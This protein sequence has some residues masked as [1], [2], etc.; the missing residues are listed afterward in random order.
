MHEWSSEVLLGKFKGIR[1]YGSEPNPKMQIWD[2]ARWVPSRKLPV[3]TGY[4]FTYAT[5]IRHRVRITED[6]R[7]ITKIDS[8]QYC[9]IECFILKCPFFLNIIYFR[10]FLVSTVVSVIQSKGFI[11]FAERSDEFQAPEIFNCSRLT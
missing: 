1:A 10:T 11:R 2:R 5:W 9:L 4:V 3:T 7:W 6:Y 8:T